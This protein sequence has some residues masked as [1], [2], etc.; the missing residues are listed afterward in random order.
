MSSTDLAV[1]SG[2][3]LSSQ[4]L[5]LP[6]STAQKRQARVHTDPITMIVAV[7]AVQHSPMLGQW[8]SWHTVL[9]RFSVTFFRTASKRSPPGILA[10][11]QLGL[12]STDMGSWFAER[13]W[14][15]LI[16]EKPC[17]L[18]NLEPLVTRG[19]ALSLIATELLVKAWVSL[20]NNPLAGQLQG[21]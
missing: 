11:S 1:F 8:D 13:F 3:S 15:S 5:G 18:R 9:S 16:A 6:V 20:E 21:R 10:L 19:L 14:P 7:P 17:S 12:R 4:P 2:S